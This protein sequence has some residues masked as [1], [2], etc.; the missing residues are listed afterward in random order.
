MEDCV[1]RNTM[2]KLDEITFVQQNIDSIV[3]T[4]EDVRY[5]IEFGEGRTIA[6]NTAPFDIESSLRDISNYVETVEGRS[7]QAVSFTHHFQNCPKAVMADATLQRVFFHLFRNAVRFS[8]VNSNIIVEVATHED[9]PIEPHLRKIRHCSSSSKSEGTI[10][11]FK[12][13]N[14]VTYPI[15]LKLINHSFHSSYSIMNDRSNDTH[16]LTSA[17]GLGLGL[18]VSYNLI[19]AMGGLLECSTDDNHLVTFQFKLRLQSCETLRIL[20]TIGRAR[21]SSVSAMNT[22][23]KNW[24]YMHNAAAAKAHVID[25]TTTAERELSESYQDMSHVHCPC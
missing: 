14:N 1:Q 15:D 7:S 18:Y 22:T 3:S 24:T 25:D 5:A 11:S 9:P 19:Q 10:C 20:P 16:G 13:T 8:P 4:A 17:K 6:I 12:I 2:P 21:A 23:V